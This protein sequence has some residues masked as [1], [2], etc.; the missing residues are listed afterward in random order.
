MVFRLLVLGDV[1]IGV[2]LLQGLLHLDAR[3]RNRASFRVITQER[4]ERLG[5]TALVLEE[6]DVARVLNKLARSEVLPERDVDV[7]VAEGVVLA[8]DLSQVHRRFPSLVVRDSGREVVG[9]VGL[10]DTVPGETTRTEEVKKEGR[11]SAS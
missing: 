4:R 11:K 3:V 10:G 9:N 2:E 7:F 5:E 8:K 6:P 1:S